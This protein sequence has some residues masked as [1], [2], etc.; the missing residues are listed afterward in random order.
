MPN[1]CQNI[2][3]F[4]HHDPQM[5]ARVVRAYNKG[6]LMGTFFPCPKELHDTVAGVVGPKGSPEAREHEIQEQLNVKQFGHKNWYDWQIANW[7]TKWDLGRGKGED[8][9]SVKRTATEF[10]LSFDSAWS[11]PIDFYVK[12]EN[13]YGY[14]IHARYFEP[15]CGF[16]GQW[17]EG[18]ED[19]WDYSGF[20]TT[21]EA[22]EFLQENAPAELLDDFGIEDWLRDCMADEAAAETEE[23]E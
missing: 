18:T 21:K 3:S 2:V 17:E 11:P 10:T 7:G 8:K 19:N 1:W 9:L 14:R 15:G 22:L 23:D 12:M 6:A 20:D 16:I 5:I 4:K 13:Q